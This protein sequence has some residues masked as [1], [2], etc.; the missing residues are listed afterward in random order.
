MQRRVN[1]NRIKK[2]EKGGI[3]VVMN[4]NSSL[5]STTIE[6]LI[7][8]FWS[9]FEEKLSDIIKSLDKEK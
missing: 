6:A 7:L 2:Y 5:V 1:G 4:G 3:A 9:V 8:W